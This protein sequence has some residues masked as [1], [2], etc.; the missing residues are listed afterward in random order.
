MSVE[1]QAIQSFEESQDILSAIN[2]LSIHL[3]LRLRG[4]GDEERIAS[5]DEARK[6]LHNF[7]EKL[8]GLIPTSS[9]DREKP[10]LG[11]NSRQRKFASNFLAA[12][13]KTQQFRSVLFHESPGYVVGLLKSNEQKD[14]EDLL[15]ALK[16]LRLLLEEHIHT[17]TKTLLGEI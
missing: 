8:E 1:W 11:T 4:F 15:E 10:I 17:D 2:T 5:S 6:T 14:W 3:K 13:T 7:L 16:E 12:R 9:E